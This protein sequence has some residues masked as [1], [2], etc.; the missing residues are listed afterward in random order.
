VKTKKKDMINESKTSNIIL[1]LAQG[2]LASGFIWAASMKLFQSPGKLEEMW[3]WTAENGMLVKLTGVLDLLAGLGLILP[4]L[5]KWNPKLTIFAAYG[6]ILLMIA[7]S[8]FHISRG[9]ASQIGINVFFLVL[10][11]FIAWGRKI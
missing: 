3:P 9:E 10:A 5:L 1:W 7:A 2:I 4:G 11:T 8:I 6:T